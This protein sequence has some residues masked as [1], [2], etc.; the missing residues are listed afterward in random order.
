[1][2]KG[3]NNARVRIYDR[4]ALAQWLSRAA[5]RRGSCIQPNYC[6][7]S[8]V[9]DPV[10]AADGK[11]YYNECVARMRWPGGA[12]VRQL[13]GEPDSGTGRGMPRL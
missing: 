8:N 11:T 2:A 1:V 5:D 13:S 9:E 12:V 4:P 3:M 6:F 10:C 7:C